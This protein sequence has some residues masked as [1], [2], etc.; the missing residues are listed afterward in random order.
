MLVNLNNGQVVATELEQ[1]HT[2]LTRLKGLM[3][4]AALMPGQGLEIRPCNSVHT[5]FMQFDLDLIFL[6]KDRRILHLERSMQP[7]R[8]SKIIKAATIVVEL[9]GGTIDATGCEIG[10]LLKVC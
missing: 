10:H 5:C 6:D 3:G 8:M 4:R 2:F 1:A 7:W 9:P